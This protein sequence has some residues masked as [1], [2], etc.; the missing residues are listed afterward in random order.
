MKILHVIESAAAGSARYVADVLLR[1]DL[2]NW[3]VT[4]AYS[5]V[6]L[7]ASF[8]DA[9]T[10]MRQKGIRIEQIPMQREIALGPDVRCLH[11][12]YQLVRKESY[13]LIHGHSSKAGFLG[14]IAGKTARRKTITVYSPHAIAISIHRKYWYLEKAAAVFTDAMVTVSEAERQEL[15]NYN[16]LSP[17]RIFTVRAGI[18][19]YAVDKRRAQTERSST[20]A[21]LGIPENAIVI[22]GVGRLSPQKD[23]LLF[24]RVAADVCTTHP[25]VHFL[26]AGEGELRRDVEHEAVKR[27]LQGRFHLLGFRTDIDALLACADVFLLTSRYESFGYVTAEAMAGKLPVV[28]AAAGATSEMV[29]DGQTGFLVSV[30]DQAAMADRIRHLIASPELRTRLGTAGRNRIE[31]HF[32]ARNVARDMERVYNTLLQRPAVDSQRTFSDSSR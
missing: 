32:D 18:D 25:N 30:G 1:L 12:L 6:R 24:V 31:M 19:I 28:A 13:D 4:L 14:R 20:R 3:N 10:T 5:P 23:P 16:L 26:W 7:D 22:A 17:N 9:I 15:I 27:P 11:S 21:Q 8:E 29:V 2:N